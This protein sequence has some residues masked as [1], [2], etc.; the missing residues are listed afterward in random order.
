MGADCLTIKLFEKEKRIEAKDAT[1][2][3][4]ELSFRPEYVFAGIH[5]SA[6][7]LV[8]DVDYKVMGNG[9]EFASAPTQLSISMQIA[10]GRAFH[11]RRNGEPPERNTHN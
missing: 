9:V 3:R 10:P 2:L 4:Y 5:K 1:Q 6:R 8:E 11:P 7:L